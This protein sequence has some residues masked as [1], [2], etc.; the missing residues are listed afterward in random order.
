MLSSQ[1]TPFTFTHTLPHADNNTAWPT[2][3]T[4]NKLATS[5]ILLTQYRA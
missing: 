4:H 5:M 1:F 3:I 2:N